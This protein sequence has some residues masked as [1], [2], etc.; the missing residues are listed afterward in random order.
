MKVTP[1]KIPDVLLLDPD[2]FN[3][4]RG[5]FIETWHRQRFA[6]LGIDHEFLQDNYSRSAQGTLRGLRGCSTWT[7]QAGCPSSGSAPRSSRAGRPSHSPT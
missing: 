5:F 2:V 4:A 6:E 3:D 7:P 1:T